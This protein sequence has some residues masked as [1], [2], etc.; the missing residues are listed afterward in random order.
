MAGL[1]VVATVLAL[2]AAARRVGHRPRGGGGAPA[3]PTGSLDG[4][5]ARPR[6]PDGGGP[7]DARRLVD[8]L[9]S[10]LDDVARGLAR[11]FVVAAVLC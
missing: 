8:E 10:V 6:R 4:A 7:V 2:G 5:G 9:P 11:R 1:I 3:A